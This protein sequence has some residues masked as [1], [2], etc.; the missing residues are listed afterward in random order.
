MIYNVPVFPGGLAGRLWICVTE[1]RG[2]HGI[3]M[4]ISKDTMNEYDAKPQST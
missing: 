4:L 3:P 1:D 2:E